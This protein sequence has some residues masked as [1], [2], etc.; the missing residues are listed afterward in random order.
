MI[1]FNADSFT[2]S[3]VCCCFFRLQRWFWETEKLRCCV[4][5]VNCGFDSEFFFSPRLLFSSSRCYWIVFSYFFFFHSFIYSFVG[6]ETCVLR[7]FVHNKRMKI[8]ITYERNVII[9]IRQVSSSRNY[10]AGTFFLILYTRTPFDRK[11]I[12]HWCSC[13]VRVPVSH[14]SCVRV[15]LRFK[16]TWKRWTEHYSSWKL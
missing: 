9:F 15:C 12:C 4:V 13:G 14:R 5:F 16:W 10:W 7:S 8:I 6:M 3:I 1:L 2:C 11:F